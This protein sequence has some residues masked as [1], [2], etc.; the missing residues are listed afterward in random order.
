MRLGSKVNHPADIV[1]T[2]QILNKF[3]VADIALNKRILVAVLNLR[4][5]GKI[6]GISQF[7]KVNNVIITTIGPVSEVSASTTPT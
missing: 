3:A 4:K 2:E 5:V 6:A 1:L 7:I